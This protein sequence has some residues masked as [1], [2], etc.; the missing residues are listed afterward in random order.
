MTATQTET[1]KAGTPA[2]IPAGSDRYPAEVVAINGKS[3]FVQKVEVMVTDAEAGTFVTGERHGAIREY[4]LRSNG[5][6]VAKGE[7]MKGGSRVV[8]GR[9]DY[10][11]DPS[12]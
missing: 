4:T 8:L 2:T 1:I 9:A 7:P 10:Y 3:V 5:R 11:M 6:W 12:F